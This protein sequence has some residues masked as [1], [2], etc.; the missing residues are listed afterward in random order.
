M[1]NP[2]TTDAPVRVKVVTDGSA[3]REQLVIGALSVGAGVLVIWLQRKMSS[4]D[5][6]LSLKMRVLLTVQDY[7]ENRAKYWNKIGS[8]AARAYLDSRPVA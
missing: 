2:I 1:T 3:I 7:S 8:A 5:F 6:F 4:P